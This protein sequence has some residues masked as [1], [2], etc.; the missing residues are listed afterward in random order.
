MSTGGP[1]VICKLRDRIKRT[2][3]EEYWGCK[4]FSLESA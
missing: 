2:G 1:V 3:I 4:E